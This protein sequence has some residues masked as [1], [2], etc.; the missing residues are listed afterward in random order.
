MLRIG[1]SQPAKTLGE[2]GGARSHEAVTIDRRGP[3]LALEGTLAV[4]ESRQGTTAERNPYT[5]C[6]LGLLVAGVALSLIAFLVLSAQAWLMALGIATLIL[7]FILLAL[8]RT[9]PRLP[10]EVGRIML[11]TGMENVTAM[12]EELGIRSRPTYLPSSLAGGRP[13]ALLPLRADTDAPRTIEA[14][15]NRLI[16]RYGPLPDDVGLL[17]TTAGSVAATMLESTPTGAAGEFEA[18]LEALL[19]GRLG[20]ADGVRVTAGNPGVCVEVRGPRITGS[21]A[22]AGGCLDSSLAAVIATV[23]AEAWNRPFAVAGEVRR[24]RRHIVQMEM[25]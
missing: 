24:G 18:A 15:P 16:V 19:V 9:V 17:V 14:L 1:L 5:W 10:P 12:V 6:G 21:P 4:D 22:E 25:R 23:A 20:A 7:S 8:A 11:E 3:V 2:K 13:R